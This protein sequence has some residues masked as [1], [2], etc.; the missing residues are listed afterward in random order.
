MSGTVVSSR[1]GWAAAS[2]LSPAGR[3]PLNLV[4]IKTGL[5]A[6]DLDRVSP[7][8]LARLLLVLAASLVAALAAVATLTVVGHASPLGPGSQLAVR[9]STPVQGPSAA[10]AGAVAAPA[11]AGLRGQ[12]AG[13]L[14]SRLSGTRPALEAPGG[15]FGAARTLSPYV[16]AC[17]SQLCLHGRPFALRMASAYGM[18]ADR[19]TTIAL[20]QQ[21][22]L[23]TLRLVNMLDEQGP[24]SGA[25]SEAAWDAVDADIAA[26]SAAGLHVELDL[27]SYRNLLVHNGQNPYTTNW[28]PFLA[29]VADRVN[30]VTHVRYADDPTIALVAFAGEVAAPAYAV[31][32]PTAQQI[33][34]FFTRTLAQWHALDPHHLRTTGG[35]LFLNDANAGINWQQL[36]DVPGDDV[37]SMHAYTQADLAFGMPNMAS[38]CA[39]RPWIVEEYGAVQSEGDTVRA[40]FFEQVASRARTLGAAG[41]G[42]WNLGPADAPGS[43]DVNPSLP[44]TWNASREED[45][46]RAS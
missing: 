20:A 13:R 17:G 45:Y 5:G 37:C 3:S 11:A 14:A 32:N 39:G 46:G 19:A 27:S 26:A 1:S 35:L 38:W 18:A 44:L 22:G 40:A 29:F 43:S 10:P 16:T 24:M 36:V 9:R 31:G 28:A 12:L 4:E 2:V 34:S 8:P 23:T 15:W 33:V 6:V 42:F 7:R 21:G 30:T 41:T 25:Y